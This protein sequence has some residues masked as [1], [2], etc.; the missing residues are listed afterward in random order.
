MRAV[1]PHVMLAG[2]PNRHHS[3]A[4]FLADHGG[5]SKQ[6]QANLHG[7][8]NQRQNDFFL[9]RKMVIERPFSRA[10]FNR[11]LVHTQGF[12]ALIQQDSAGD[13]Q[14]SCLP[15]VKFVL[16]TANSRP[17]RIMTRRQL[18]SNLRGQFHCEL[19]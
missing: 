17:N 1:P 8:A 9:V 2:K 15:L 16:L 4:R 5:N 7:L 19:T 12:V 14:N 13:M 3:L 18:L 11:Q 6:L 10:Q